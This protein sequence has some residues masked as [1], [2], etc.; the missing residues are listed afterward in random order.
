MQRRDL[1]PWVILFI[2]LVF[3]LAALLLPESGGL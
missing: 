1:M 2:V 3:V